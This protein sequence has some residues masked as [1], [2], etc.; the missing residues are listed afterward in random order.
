MSNYVDRI[1]INSNYFYTY[2][3]IPKF[4]STFLSLSRHSKAKKSPMT[5]FAEIPPKKRKEKKKLVKIVP[6]FRFCC[7]GSGQ[8][9]YEAFLRS[10]CFNG[11]SSFHS[12]LEDIGCCCSYRLAQ[13]L[14]RARATR[15]RTLMQQ[16][17]H[18]RGNR[19]KKQFFS[20]S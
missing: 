10:K 14:S 6:T 13:L 4:L 16:S 18:A 3:E 8:K 9:F 2:Y 12:P 11:A 17:I 20:L 7:R 1:S 15:A 5:H 19:C